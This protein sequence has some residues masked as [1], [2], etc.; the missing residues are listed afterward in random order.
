MEA[1]RAHR[2][3][4][5]ACTLLSAALLVSA[6]AAAENPRAPARANA[7]TRTPKRRHIAQMS[8]REL[9][10]SEY[11]IQIL[12]P[13]SGPREPY[14]WLR[15]KKVDG[16]FRFIYSGFG[17][18]ITCNGATLNDRLRG[19]H[20]D[21]KGQNSREINMTGLFALLYGEHGCAQ[22]KRAKTMQKIAAHNALADQ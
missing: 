5:R 20:N 9:N 15:A 17:A 18:V 22:A 6:C 21:M 4:T 14:K 1:H 11:P 16:E 12:M 13:R 8:G 3:A 10:A 19:F 7:N 2:A